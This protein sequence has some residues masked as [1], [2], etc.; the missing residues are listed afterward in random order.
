MPFTKSKLHH[1][2][3][4]PDYFGSVEDLLNSSAAKEFDTLLF[5]CSDHGTAPDNVSFA[6]PGR[7]MIVQH[8]GASIPRVSDCE[9][10]LDRADVL[11]LLLEKPIDKIIVCGHLGCG[12]IPTWL[13]ATA[14]DRD[15]GKFRERFMQGTLKPVLQAY[16]GVTGQDLIDCLVHEHVLVQLDNLAT[17]EEIDSRLR[18]GTL[19]LHGWVVDDESARIS[20]FEPTNN[21]FKIL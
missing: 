16:P 14:E 4:N 21:S 17:H 19:K 10:G 6:T 13:K 20:S 1:Q 15:T 3:L 2:R 11:N 7:M 8:L 18:S 5:A 9:K 12:V